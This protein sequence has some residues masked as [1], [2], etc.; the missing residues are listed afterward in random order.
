LTY[1]YLYGQGILRFTWLKC[2]SFV[3]AQKVW[4]DMKANDS[5]HCRSCHR[6]D[7][8]NLE[9]Q[10]AKAKSRHAKAKAEGK[11]CIE[12]HFAIAHKEP[13]GPGPAELFAETAAKAL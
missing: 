12:C 10:T 6:E 11:T 5:H 4:R 2:L 13:E 1:L 3:M 7:K 9:L 8:M